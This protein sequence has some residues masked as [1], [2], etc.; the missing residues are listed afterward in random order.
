MD[1]SSSG[2]SPGGAGNNA[3]WMLDVSTGTVYETFSHE[4][5]HGAARGAFDPDGNAWFGGRAGPLVQIV[6]EIDEGKGNSHAFVLAADAA[7]PV[8][9][10]LYRDAGQEW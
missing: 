6:N 2:G 3:A 9:R 8:H 5:D 1:G 4:Q 7:V 10:F